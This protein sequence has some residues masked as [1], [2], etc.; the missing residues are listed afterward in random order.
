[1]ESLNM[2]VAPNKMFYV[3]IA[4]VVGGLVYLL[5]PIL[6]PFLAGCLLAY[7]GDPLVEKLTSWKVPRVLSVVIIFLG[8]FSL[9]ILFILLLIPLI[10]KQVNLLVEVLPAIV[11]WLQNTIMPWISLHFGIE[12]IVN[13]ETLKTTLAENWTKAGSTAGWM[14][15][16]VLHSSKTVIIWMSYL[17]LI[18]VVT[19]YLLRDWNKIIK[20]VRGLLPR[21]LE[22]VVVKLAK[23]CDVTL[24]AFIRGQLLVMLGL[25]IIYSV[26][27]TL[28]GLQVGLMIGLISGLLS[29]VPYLG[30]I[31]GIVVASVVALV[32]FGTFKAVLSVWVVFAIGQAAEGW[33]LTPT[34]VGNRIGLHPVAVIF[35]VLAGGMLFGFFGVLLALPVAAVIMVLLRHLNERY[36]GSQFYK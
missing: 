19:F 2:P 27:L 9:L 1:M 6:T 24:S 13:I 28:I 20:N 21:H 33:F 12:E 32:Q 36:R 17:F 3:T 35:S 31:T 22:P 34:L 11:N 26:G 15:Q 10:E 29:I 5:A 14:A 8:I 7:F 4:L 16:Q 25:G 30:F 23:E 18:P